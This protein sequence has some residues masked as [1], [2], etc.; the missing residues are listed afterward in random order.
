[1]LLRLKDIAG[2]EGHTEFLQPCAVE[3]AG[4]GI[5]RSHVCVRR[6]QPCS[7]DAIEGFVG[8]ERGDVGGALLQGARQRTRDLMGISFQSESHDRVQDRRPF[9]FQRGRVE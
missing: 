8:R 9:L 4:F 3:D 7:I 2:L 6:R 5:G 1:M